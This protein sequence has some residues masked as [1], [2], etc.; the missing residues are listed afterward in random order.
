MLNNFD[1]P[2]GVARSEAGG[3]VYSDY[4]QLTVARNPQNF[5]YYYKSY[6]DQTI[7]M[8]DVKKLDL[9]SKEIMM[10][11]IRSE[12]PVTDMTERFR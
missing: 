8:V 6:A 3:L 1:I 11:C 9:N 10:Q 7:R 4:T 12:Q 5:R 2:V